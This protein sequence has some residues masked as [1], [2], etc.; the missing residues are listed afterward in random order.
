MNKT[1][2]YNAQVGS[3]LQI[4]IKD[5]EPLQKQIVEMINACKKMVVAEERERVRKLLQTKYG[6]GTEEALVLIKP[7]ISGVSQRPA[8]EEVLSILAPLDKPLT[9]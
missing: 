2:F 3:P 1:E 5:N 7:T 8:L 9:K 4:A 6:D